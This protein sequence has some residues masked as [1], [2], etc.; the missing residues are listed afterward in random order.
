MGRKPRKPLV[1]RGEELRL[2]VIREGCRDDR[3]QVW[4]PQGGSDLA[5]LGFLCHQH[6][7]AA[8]A[9]RP[10]A[11]QAP[12][13]AWRGTGTGGHVEDQRRPGQAC[14]HFRG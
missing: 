4:K 9:E 5:R 6:C 3:R 1:N 12:V 11:G 8:P 7:P 10:P 2:S 14:G 13:G